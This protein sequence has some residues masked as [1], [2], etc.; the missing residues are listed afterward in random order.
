MRT[1]ENKNS[2]WL[3]GSATIL[4]LVAVVAALIA[5]QRYHEALPL[6]AFGVV[7]VLTVVKSRLV[8]MDFM[9]LR[10]VHPR[11]AA[12]LI[13]WPAFFAIAAAAKAAF[14]TFGS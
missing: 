9:G 1:M 8:V 2:T 10:C 5:A 3:M 6:A 14:A 7:L 4:M 11:L 12:S 13:A